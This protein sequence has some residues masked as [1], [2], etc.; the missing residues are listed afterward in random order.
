VI[1]EGRAV[2]VSMRVMSAG[3]GYKY[4][5]RTVAAGDGER[6]PSTPLTRY[7][8]AQGTPPGRWLGSGLRGL[9]EGLVVEGD[10][11]TEAQLQLLIG[12]GRDPVTGE[13]VGVVATDDGGVVRV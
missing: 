4:L 2:T 9:G 8:S 12:L 13:A 5:L 6:S 7:Y 11:V 10:A 1:A 3:D